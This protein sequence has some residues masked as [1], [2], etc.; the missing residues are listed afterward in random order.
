MLFC[1]ILG[2]SSTPIHL[3]THSFPLILQIPMRL[4]TVTLG[5]VLVHVV[6]VHSQAVPVGYNL[7]LKLLDN[8]DAVCSKGNRAGYYHYASTDPAHA[9]DYQIVMYNPGEALL[10]CLPPGKQNLTTSL[11]NCKFSGLKKGDTAPPLNPLLNPGWD[12]GLF[13]NNCTDNPTF[14]KWNRIVLPQCDGMNWMGDADKVDIGGYTA[15]FR[16]K[17]VLFETIKQVSKDFSFSSKTTVMMAGYVGGAHALYSYADRIGAA[18]K[19]AGGVTQYSVVLLDGFWPRW[20]GY[21]DGDVFAQW[22]GG[23]TSSITDPTIRATLPDTG[24]YEY[25]NMSGSVHPTC[26]AEQRKAGLPEWEC[27]LS[28]RAAQYIESPAYAF[29]QAWGTFG[30][31]CLVNSEIIYDE[32]AWG[33]WHVMCDPRDGVLHTCVEYG[34]TCSAEYLQMFVNPYI[35]NTWK[36]MQEINVFNQKGKAAF[37]HSCHVG[38]EDTVTTM[39]NEIAIDGVTMDKAFNDWWGDHTAGVPGKVYAPCEWAANYSQP[40]KNC[41]N[42]SCP[43]IAYAQELKSSLDLDWKY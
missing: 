42:P 35:E 14:C 13:S 8:A 43:N 38:G 5:L 40:F 12:G 37:M 33:G 17:K 28:P 18:L 10:W 16:G 27:L 4:P 25:A 20:S 32:A 39:W 7:T 9:D 26:L 24:V 1:A 15:Y 11:G 6:A 34:W 19:E 41:C 23:N 36:V 2:S 29:T 21:H 22:Y 30:S 31:F 3:L